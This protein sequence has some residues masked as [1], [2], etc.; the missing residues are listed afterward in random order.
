MTTYKIGEEISFNIDFEIEAVLGKRL[1]VKQ[2]DKGYIDSKGHIHYTTGQAR[3]KIQ[4]LGSEIEVKGY[5]YSNIAKMLFKRLNNEFNLKE[6]L[7]DYDVSETD[8][9]DSLE[10]ILSDIL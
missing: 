2:G 9:I 6:A 10:D 5:D 1:Q 8:V 4:S 3:G 7:D